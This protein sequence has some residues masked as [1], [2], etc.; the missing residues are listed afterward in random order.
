MYRI[1]LPMFARPLHWQGPPL[2][3]AALGLG[4]VGTDVLEARKEILYCRGKSITV[5]GHPLLWKDSAKH[6]KMIQGLSPVRPLRTDKATAP[7]LPTRIILTRT[8]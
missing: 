2:G 3:L 8:C 6:G 1:S 4:E 5:E 7:D